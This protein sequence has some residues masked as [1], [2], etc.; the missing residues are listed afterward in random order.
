LKPYIEKRAVEI[1]TYIVEKSATVRQAAKNFGVSKSTVHKDVAE[2]LPQI[3]VELAKEAR[4]VLDVNKSER[5]IR[6]GMATRKKYAHI[7]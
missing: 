2:R 3:D 1:G 5:H 4:S 6:G 7:H